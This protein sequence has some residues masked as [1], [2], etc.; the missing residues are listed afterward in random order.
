MRP[1]HLPGTRRQHAAPVT[2]SNPLD[3]APT[4][5]LR[6]RRIVNSVYGMPDGEH[7]ICV[8][9]DG[10]ATMWEARTG[11]FLGDGDMGPTKPTA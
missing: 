11:H 10:R 5:Q 7:L 4:T 6:H 9:E 1:I 3:P 2:N 8:S